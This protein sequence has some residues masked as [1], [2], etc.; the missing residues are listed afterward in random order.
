[1][2]RVRMF[3]DWDNDSRGLIERLK[4]QTEG[5][6]GDQYQDIL[7]VDDDSFDKAIVFNYDCDYPFTDKQ[8]INLVLEPPE[9]YPVKLITHRDIYSF[10]NTHGHHKTAYGLGFATVSKD[11]FRPD[12]QIRNRMLMICSNK[13]YTPYHHKRLEIK[14]ALLKTSMDIHFYGR[15]MVRNGGR[16]YGEIPP[17][18]KYKV[19]PYYK[20][21]IDFENSHNAVTDKYFDAIL[22]GTVPITNSPVLNELAPNS[23]ELIDF[24]STIDE[25]I[26]QI[27]TIYEQEDQ[28]YDLNNA[29]NE[30]LSGKMCLAKW[31]RDRVL[32]DVQ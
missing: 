17:M 27:Q 16:I 23:F 6:D 24:N 4:Q 7:F 2:I 32:E 30:I 18:G 25:I 26:D 9:I 22:C 13:T 14:E 1:M 10:V 20:Y 5:F 3:C 8:A 28:E 19:L 31:I 12:W 15:G 29:R 21:V 11:T